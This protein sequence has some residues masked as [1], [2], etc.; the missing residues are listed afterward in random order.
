MFLTASNIKSKHG[1]FTRNGGFSAGEYK[2]LNCGFGSG[3]DR[4]IVQ[5]NRDLVLEKL[6][7]QKLVTAYQIHS[8]VAH[9]VNGSEDKLEGDALVT[10]K[11]GIALGVLAADCC[12]ILFEDRKAGIIGA[13]H[14]GWKGARFGIIGSTIR[15]MQNMGAQDIS[16]AVGPCIQQGSY[17]VSNDFAQ[18]FATEGAYNAEF[19]SQSVKEGHFMF[20]LPAYIEM[21]LKKNGIENITVLAEDTLS[22]PARFYSYRRGTLEGKKE[23]GRQI[24]AICM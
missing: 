22:Q 6:G 15:T 2:G 7:G 8:D 10:D 1:F 12:P 23:Y 4:E 24:S 9:V 20:N 3:E 16:A 18:V 19:F 13:A 21:K 11:P 14:A 5:K 17:E